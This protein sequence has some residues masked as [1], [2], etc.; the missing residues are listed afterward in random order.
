MALPFPV[1]MGEVVHGDPHN[2]H[3]PTAIIPGM[4]RLLPVTLT[5][6]SW[7]AACAIVA[8]HKPVP[9]LLSLRGV[10]PRVGTEPVPMMALRVNDGAPVPEGCF[11][12]AIAWLDAHAH[13]TGA[14]GSAPVI[15]CWL[16]QSRSVVF[17]SA[18][19][20]HRNKVS[21]AEAFAHVCYHR[22]NAYP[23]VELVRSA[24]MWR[25]EKIPEELR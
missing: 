24:Y 9:A 23:H 3:Y 12:A 20:A 5:I 17:A 11:D 7:Y 1:N 18:W 16:G 19:I 10:L 13:F 15:A 6:A 25:G 22:G 8:D 2:L 14:E 4:S 21:L